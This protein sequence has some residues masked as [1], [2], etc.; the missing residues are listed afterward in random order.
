VGPQGENSPP[1]SQYLLKGNLR[2]ILYGPEKDGQRRQGGKKLDGVEE[3]DEI[4]FRFMRPG[5]KVKPTQSMSRKVLA[6]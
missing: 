3:G 1:A 6:A 4:H 5:I 2:L